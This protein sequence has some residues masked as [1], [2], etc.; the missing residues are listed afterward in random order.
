MSSWLKD[1]S[2]GELIKGRSN[3][4][5]AGGQPE[6]IEGWHISMVTPGPADT[7]HLRTSTER[8]SEPL[9]KASADRRSRIKSRAGS[10]FRAMSNL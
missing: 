3:I 9:D 1:T 7:P 5:Q 2:L 8:T 10:F 6:I 4:R